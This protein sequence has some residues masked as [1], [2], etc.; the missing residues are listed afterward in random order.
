MLLTSCSA[1]AG[2]E[3]TDR[4]AKTLATAIS[5]PRQDSAAGFARA[6]L[7][8]WKGHGTQLAVLEMQEIPVPD[9]NPAK[10]FARL[11][12]RIHRP[13]KDPVMFGSRT[14][15]LNACYSMDFNFYGI[16][17]E[18]ERVSCPDKATPVTPPPTRGVRIPEGAEEALRKVL[19]DLP[20]APTEAQV[21]DA[22][23]R[24]MPKP[25][26]DPETKLADHPPL[27]DVR[28]EGQDVGVSLR[29]DS[30][31]IGSRVRGAVTAGHL[32]RKEAMPGERGCSATTAL[33]K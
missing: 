7:A 29:A 5:Y 19:S 9:Q 2:D 6:A 24:D 22:L 30:C 3:A 23:G 13:A 15:E 18:P 11:V 27:V 25:R 17:D 16:I 20:P 12:I 4:Q 26:I 14:E 33:G 28:I 1:P 10:R 21:R 8:V 31:L 32:S